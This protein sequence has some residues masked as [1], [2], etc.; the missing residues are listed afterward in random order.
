[1]NRFLT[2][3]SW[4]PLATAKC[5]EGS[6]CLLKLFPTLHR[7]QLLACHRKVPDREGNA[8]SPTCCSHSLAFTRCWTLSLAPHPLPHCPAGSSSPSH[9]LL[10]ST[11]WGLEA[12]TPSPLSHRCMAALIPTVSVCPQPTLLTVGQALLPICRSFCVSE[13][14]V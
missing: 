8:V 6:E 9:T 2:K 7:Q 10:W 5:A 14:G 4:L 3:S 12:E 1:M 11:P 13:S